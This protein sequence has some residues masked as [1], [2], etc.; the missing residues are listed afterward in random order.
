[1]TT[2]TFTDQQITQTLKWLGTAFTLAGA[3]L[4]AAAMD[5]YNV[6]CLNV[7]SIWFLWWAWRIRDTAMITVN[8][9]LLIIYV[10][11]TVRTLLYLNC[12]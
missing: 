1:M 12:S 7:G 10:I 6:W 5:P 11:G 2:L 3:S 8:G 9:G 4:T